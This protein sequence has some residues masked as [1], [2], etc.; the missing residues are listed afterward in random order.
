MRCSVFK[1]NFRISDTKSVKRIWNVGDIH[2]HEQLPET[3]AI[4]PFQGAYYI[5]SENVTLVISK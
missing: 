2:Q 4:S 5:S 1:E 3:A